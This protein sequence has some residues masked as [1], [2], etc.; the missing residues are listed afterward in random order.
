MYE[1][2]GKAVFK[3]SGDIEYIVQSGYI[4]SKILPDVMEVEMIKNT[5]GLSK[6]FHL[7]T[8]Y[9]HQR[10]REQMKPELRSIIQ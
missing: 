3:E 7:N 8:E 2:S 4:I 1:K 5:R 9:A 10:I 6:T